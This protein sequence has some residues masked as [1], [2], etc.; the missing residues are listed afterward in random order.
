MIL[1]VALCLFARRA[2]EC[3]DPFATYMKLLYNVCLA[4]PDVATTRWSL[5]VALYTDASVPLRQLRA[6]L[7]RLRAISGLTE[8]VS[9][10]EQ[11]VRWDGMLGTVARF[12]AFAHHASDSDAVLVLDADLS[13]DT[14]WRRAVLD[15][16]AGEADDKQVLRL[17]MLDYATSAD[18]EER[19]WCLCAGL[20]G[21]RGR[22]VLLRTGV[23]IGAAAALRIS[24]VAQGQAVYGCDQSWLACTV[25]PLL[26]PLPTLTVQMV[27]NHAPRELPLEWRSTGPENTWD[28]RLVDTLSFL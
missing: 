14:H 27:K 17:T 20:L 3:N 25:W 8:V 22:D 24:D 11:R 16:L 15:W 19:R 4:L 26:R 21:L 2:S 1:T 7:K 6:L 9:H 28:E 13:Q 10:H 18:L 12:G 5:R 23:A